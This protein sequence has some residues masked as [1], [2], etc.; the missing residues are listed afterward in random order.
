MK[1]S[2]ISKLASL[3]TL[4]CVLLPL[5]QA[6]PAGSAPNP[7]ETYRTEHFTLTWTGDP[8]DPD[9]PSLVDKDD[10]GFADRACATIAV[11]MSTPDSPPT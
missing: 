10:D 4:T 7:D 9:S 3:L 8:D 2:N 5:A 1:A 11:L 6:G